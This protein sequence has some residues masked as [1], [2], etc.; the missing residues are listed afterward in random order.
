MVFKFNFSAVLIACEIYS[1]VG[2][3][4]LI[5]WTNLL[6][7]KLQKLKAHFFSCCQA[8][9]RGEPTALMLWHHHLKKFCYANPLSRA[10]LCSRSKKGAEGCSSPFTR[11]STSTEDL[12]AFLVFLPRCHGIYLEKGWRQTFSRHRETIEELF[13]AGNNSGLNLWCP[14]E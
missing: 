2:S 8:K 1:W 10:T 6:K 11:K 14:F 3:L 4:P 7:R 5:R 12:F 13:S 9:A